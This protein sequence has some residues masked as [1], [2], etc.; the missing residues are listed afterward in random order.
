MPKKGEY[1]RFKNYERN[2]KSPFMIFAGFKNILVVEGNGK[3]N[4]NECLTYK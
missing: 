4:A 1:V 2:M 3:Q